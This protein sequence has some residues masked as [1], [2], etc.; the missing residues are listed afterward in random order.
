[1]AD[2]IGYSDRYHDDAMEFE[3]RHVILPPR[4]QRDCPRGRLLREDEWRGKLGIQMSC[5]WEHCML[6]LR[7]PHVLIFKRPYVSPPQPSPSQSSSSC[8]DQ[9]IPIPFTETSATAMVT[10]ITTQPH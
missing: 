5:G 7:E 2:Q 10:T 9:V 1:M 6:Y 8:P 3:Y 4:L